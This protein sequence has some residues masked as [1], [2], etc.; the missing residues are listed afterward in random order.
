MR[1]QRM[2]TIL[3]L[4]LLAVAARLAQAQTY[5]VVYNF[6]NYPDGSAPLAAPIADSDGNLYGTTFGGGSFICERQD[7]FCGTVYKI[8]P[9]GNESVLYAFTGGQD[10]A[11]PEASVVRDAAGNLYGTTVGNGI[12]NSVSTVFKVD[13]SGNETVLHRFQ[14]SATGGCCA[15]S[16]LVLDN[17][18]NLYGTTPYDGDTQCGFN[19]LGCGIIFELNIATGKFTVI[20]TFTT[21]ADGLQP[22]GGLVIDQ[23]GA[24][25]GITQG[26]GNGCPQAVRRGCGTIFRLDKSG[27]TVLHSFSGGADGGTPNYRPV[28][29][30]DGNLYGITNQGGDL[31]CQPPLGCGTIF[32]LAADGTFTVLYSFPP[33]IIRSPGYTGIVRDAQGNI[34]GAKAVDGAHNN[35][36][37]FQ[38][39]TS[40]NLTDIYDYPDNPS[41]GGDYPAGLLLDSGALYGTNEEAGQNLNECAGQG[42][43]TVFKITP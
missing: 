20:H 23:R 42:C 28:P 18:G 35:G 19:D 12:T 5:S 32:K 30:S 29:D 6:Q 36:F 38:L 4:L 27:Y 8:D 10:G 15:D 37:V 2:L 11:D 43:G 14:G 9:S 21:I 13:P 22:E 40:G 26:G 24:L 25:F 34:Y 31:T 33:N 1:N 41:L 7:S 39:D 3:F 17:A 16:P